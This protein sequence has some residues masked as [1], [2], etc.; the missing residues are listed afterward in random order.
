MRS[1]LQ[2]PE[3]DSRTASGERTTNRK[4]QVKWQQYQNDDTEVAD[5]GKD[6][7][8]GSFVFQSERLFAET[9]YCFLAVRWISV[10]RCALRAFARV[11][12]GGVFR[13]ETEGKRVAAP[14]FEIDFAV[15]LPVGESEPPPLFDL[16]FVFD[17][18]RRQSVLRKEF[19]RPRRE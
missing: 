17:F 18:K 11:S 6:P 10:V 14:A 8:C 3:I 2:A 12:P 4:Q 19:P 15:G 7:L 13:A 16:G 1:V 5:Y 9:D